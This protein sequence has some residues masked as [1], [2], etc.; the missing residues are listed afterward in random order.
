MIAKEQ[1]KKR[2]LKKKS[3]KGV[4][5]LRKD[6]LTR[7]FNVLWKTAKDKIVV[8]LQLLRLKSV[9]H[10]KK[11]CDI[12][13]IGRAT[14]K[15]QKGKSIV[16]LRLSKEIAKLIKGNKVASDLYKRLFK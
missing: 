2:S 4:P 10:G 6:E 5:L 3:L 14:F 16:E 15:E 7:L 9:W 11:Y 8:T 12:E 1:K 13:D